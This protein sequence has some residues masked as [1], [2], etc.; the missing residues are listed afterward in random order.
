MD[1]LHVVL[2]LDQDVI[3]VLTGRQNLLDPGRQWMLRSEFSRQ[4]VRELFS[5]SDRRRVS[6]TQV[7][8]LEPPTRISSA[9]E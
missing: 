7:A 9:E 4:F 8:R 3:A 1:Y 2:S 6:A 5:V